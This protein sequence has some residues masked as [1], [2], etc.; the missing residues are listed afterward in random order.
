MRGDH[1]VLDPIW[2]IDE[3]KTRKILNEAL[4]MPCGAIIGNPVSGQYYGMKE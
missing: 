3:K 2:P 4:Y 1:A